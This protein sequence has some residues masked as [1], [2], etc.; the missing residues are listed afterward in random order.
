MVGD[1]QIDE[2]YLCCCCMKINQR[3][4]TG[5]FCSNCD[6]YFLYILVY[7]VTPGTFFALIGLYCRDHTL[8][9][10][11]RLLLLCVIAGISLLISLLNGICKCKKLIIPRLLEDKR[12]QTV[13]HNLNLRQ[14]LLW[15]YRYIPKIND[16]LRIDNRARKNLTQICK[17]V[18][19]RVEGYS[20][21]SIFLTGSTA[22]RFNIPIS[23]SWVLT[24]GLDEF[25]HAI[26]SDFDYM[27]SSKL[28]K[29]SFTL[30]EEKYVVIT[31]K[32]N[33]QPGFVLLQ[34]QDQII[35]AK[36]FKADFYKVLK[37]L[38]LRYFEG[39]I[40]YERICCCCLNKNGNMNIG[41]V[42]IKGPA[43]ELSISTDYHTVDRFYADITFS[44]KCTQWP[45]RISNWCNRDG[46]RWPDGH[47]VE[48]IVKQG[49]HLVA[50]SQLDDTKGETWRISFS[51]AEVELSQLVPEL[52]RVCFIGLKIIA[53]DHLREVCPKI[54]SYQ[55]KCIFFNTLE[56]TEPPMWLYDQNLEHC[57]QLLLQA[58]V[59][60]IDDKSCPHFWIPGINLFADLT[61][62]D[63]SKLLKKMRQVQESP[64]Q[65]IEPFL[66][67]TALLGEGKP[68]TRQP[69]SRQTTNNY[70]SFEEAAVVSFT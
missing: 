21:L 24:R 16:M 11:G 3:K 50:K 35:N 23:Y 43:I 20:E 54:K 38:K 62:L 19:D 7:V 10:D 53:K 69:Q 63:V 30:G 2:G 65:F 56:I 67:A 29:A 46:K 42:E 41:K 36:K 5:S 25:S 33:V 57:F 64:S 48:R 27:I 47:D 44:I 61:D 70:G 60:A 66:R 1:D 49:C 14:N 51:Q 12:K 13:P 17:L 32:P 15:C 40:P 37:K 28:I 68:I 31:N 6:R 26:V 8:F 22:E 9:D 18:K 45:D 52:A 58:V 55:M 4:V 59:Q 34:D 39:Y